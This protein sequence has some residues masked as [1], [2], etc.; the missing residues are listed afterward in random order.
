MSKENAPKLRLKINILCPFKNNEKKKKKL[1][2][3][4]QI[5]STIFKIKKKG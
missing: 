3:V 2:E 5:S 1:I 4:L